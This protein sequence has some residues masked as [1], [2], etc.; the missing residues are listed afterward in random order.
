M[1]KLDFPVAPNKKHHNWLHQQI[2]TY[3][4]IARFFVFV[5]LK[6]KSVFLG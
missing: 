4:R 1:T 3:I 2:F 6:E 5:D